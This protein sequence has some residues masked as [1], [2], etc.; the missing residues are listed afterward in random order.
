[1]LSVI[2]SC[3]SSL[4]SIYAIICI[5]RI[6]LTWFPRLTFHPFTKFLAKICDPYLDLF[7]RIK[8]LRVGNIDFSPALALCILSAA[9]SILTGLSHGISLSVSN[10]LALI[11]QTVWSIISAVLTFIIII[12]VIRTIILYMN[13]G[14]SYSSNM[15]IDAIDQTLASIVGNISKTFTGHKPVPY[16]TKI[17]ISIV[18]LIALYVIGVILFTQIIRIIYLLPF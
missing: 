12:L 10:V 9:S 3:L 7:H 5:V 6:L 17:I 11:V 13:K 4:F 8:F 16:Q 14:N 15:I 2:F 1:M 18:V